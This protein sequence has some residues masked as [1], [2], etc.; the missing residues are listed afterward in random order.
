MGLLVMFITFQSYSSS[1][2]S[3]SRRSFNLQS[4][5]IIL[6][7]RGRKKKKIEILMKKSKRSTLYSS[8]DTV[9]F[10]DDDDDYS[11]DLNND[12]STMYN[13]PVTYNLEEINK[14]Q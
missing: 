5:P 9:E 11:N 7:G 8:D 4:Y 12:L 3:S 1:S 2:S 10:L 13:L 14:Q 6:S